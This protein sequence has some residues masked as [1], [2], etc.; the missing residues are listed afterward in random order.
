[1]K[2]ALKQCGKHV[3][4]VASHVLHGNEICVVFSRYISY[5]FLVYNTCG[6]STI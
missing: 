5:T 2:N 4:N 6:S 3:V 1:M